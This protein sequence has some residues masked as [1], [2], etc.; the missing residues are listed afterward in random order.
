MSDDCESYDEFGFIDDADELADLSTVSD[1]SL[2]S[3]SFISCSM[4]LRSLFLKSY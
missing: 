4:F 1:L 2:F 3:N